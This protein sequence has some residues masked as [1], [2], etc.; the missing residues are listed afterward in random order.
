[1]SAGAAVAV[2]PATT[3]TG[4]A[5]TPRA[6]VA[7]LAATDPPL[8]AGAA[9]PSAAPQSGGAAGT[10]GTADT[11]G[12]A[13]HPD[14]AIAAGPAVAPQPSAGPAGTTGR[15]GAT[16]AAGPAVA[17]QPGRPARTA[18]LT[19]GAGPA[20]AAV[21][22]QD[23]AGPAGLPGP[24]RPVGAV[25][26][27]RA[28]QQRHGRR[29]DRT[30]QLLLDVGGLGAGIRACRAREGLHDLLVKRRRLSSQRLIGLRVAAKQ[31][32]HGGGHLIGTGGQ[33]TRRGGRGRSIGRADRRADACQIRRRRAQHFRLC[34]QKRHDRPPESCGYEQTCRDRAA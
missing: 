4:A 33:H 2:Q 10:A 9:G 3:A 24:R 27:Q 21:A 20:V 12:V 11:T 31:R 5:D 17:D 28:P 6:A 32:R 26:D 16:Q 23:P 1:M 15:A 13:G 14:P 19:G 30:Q 7:G 8:P 25:A 18:G 34:K 29:V 22:V